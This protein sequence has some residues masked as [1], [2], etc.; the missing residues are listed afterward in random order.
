MIGV[1]LVALG[2]GATPD[3]GEELATSDGGEGDPACDGAVGCTPDCNRAAPAVEA[4]LPQQTWAAMFDG[5][6]S[7]LVVAS[8]SPY[9]LAR[10][11]ADGTQ[12]WST[13]IDGGGNGVAVERIRVGTQIVLFGA[14]ITGAP[15]VGAIWRFA[16]DG[17]AL[18]RVDDEAERD[19]V[20]GAVAEDGDAVVLVGSLD[21]FGTT[22]E[23]RSVDG[24]VVSSRAID[25][26]G[27][28]A[29]HRIAV[30]EDDVVI[31]VGSAADA[32][33]PAI[34]RIADD[35]V[36]PTRLPASDYAGAYFHAVAADGEGGA[37]A[38]GDSAGQAIIARVA[39]DGSIAWISECSP[40]RGAA[41]GIVVANDRVIVH[42]RRFV[43][44]DGCTDACSG[45][46]TPWI[47]HL[48]R[49][50]SVIARDTPLAL[51]TPPDD[52]PFESVVALAP[53]DD[54]EVIALVGGG[55]SSYLARFPW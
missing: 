53:N 27:E 43:R 33:V 45:A 23:R 49:D 5:D 9:T 55:T 51:G 41:N 18:G 48:G 47:E 17:T 2:C 36:T 19:Y 11:S 25:P 20:D 16:A 35:D 30:L 14:R 37:V 22:V 3:A 13:P 28:I 15:R 7:V 26:G 8:G 32:A 39:E 21:E 12:Q 6:G 46:Y 4:T 24:D 54:G 42:G 10:L 31:A 29:A 44:E 38:V 50:G 34:V 52:Y 1:L 40:S